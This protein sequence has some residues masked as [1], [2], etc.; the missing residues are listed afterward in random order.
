M[1]LESDRPFQRLLFRVRMVCKP[2]NPFHRCND[3]NHELFTP[4]L[5]NRFLHLPPCSANFSEMY[6][7]IWVVVECVHQFFCILFTPS[8]FSAFSRQSR[9]CFRSQMR[10]LFFIE[11]G[12]FQCLEPP[13]RAMVLSGRLNQSSN[14]RTLVVSSIS[15]NWPVF[16]VFYDV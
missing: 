15:K 6:F 4:L 13:S 12:V 11:K 8:I 3:S 2:C 16:L 7:W 5:W 1:Y 9:W 10:L 14:T